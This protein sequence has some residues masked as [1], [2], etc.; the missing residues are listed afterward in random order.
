MNVERLPFTDSPL[1]FP[2][3]MLLMLGAS[4][5]LYWRLRRNHWL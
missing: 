1:G 3:L 4:G 2:V 5:Y